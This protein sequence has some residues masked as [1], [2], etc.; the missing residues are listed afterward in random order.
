MYGYEWVV[1][2]PGAVCNLTECVQLYRTTPN[3]GRRR[4]LTDSGRKRVHARPQ[5][6]MRDTVHDAH[7]KLVQSSRR[8]LYAF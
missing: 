6:V 2:C 7:T 1:G 4:R 5:M 8:A 3:D